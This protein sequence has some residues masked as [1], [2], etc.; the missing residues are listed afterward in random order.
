MLLVCVVVNYSGSVLAQ[1]LCSKCEG[2]KQANVITL[3]KQE[4]RLTANSLSLMWFLETKLKHLVKTVWLPANTAFPQVVCVLMQVFRKHVHIV[5]VVYSLPFTTLIFI[6]SHPQLEF[7]PYL[8][9]LICSR[10]CSGALMYNALMKSPQWKH[11]KAPQGLSRET[12]TL[13]SLCSVASAPSVLRGSIQRNKTL[14][15]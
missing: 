10:S 9:T 2:M 14:E 8:S 7:P 3:I 15:Q 6:F 5:C 11:T 4:E 1:I 12:L 13:F